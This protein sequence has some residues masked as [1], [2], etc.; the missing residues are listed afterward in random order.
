M[1]AD[2]RGEFGRESHQ[3]LETCDFVR[4]LANFLST[5]EKETQGSDGNPNG[6]VGGIQEEEM[7]IS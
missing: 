4:P 3:N 6:K 1:A 5:P 7:A 2:G